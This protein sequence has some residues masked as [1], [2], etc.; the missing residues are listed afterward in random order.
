[1]IRAHVKNLFALWVFFL[2]NQIFVFLQLWVQCLYWL[3]SSQ[4][5]DLSQ[6]FNFFQNSR[7]EVKIQIFLPLIILSLKSEF[8]MNFT[9][10]PNPLLHYWLLKLMVFPSNWLLV[11]LS[12]KCQRN[13]VKCII[14]L[15]QVMSTNILCIQHS[16]IKCWVYNDI[17]M[18]KATNPNSSC[19][20]I[21]SINLVVIN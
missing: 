6:N 9:H 5:W 19:T 18:R 14:H 20:E 15:H 8:W 10:V 21:L 17:H 4:L 1:M 7:I 12:V 11:N 2:R 3:L 16:N 13:I